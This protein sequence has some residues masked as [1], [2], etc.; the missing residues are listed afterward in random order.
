M[1]N[2]IKEF[3]EK[4]KDMNFDTFKKTLKHP[5]FAIDAWDAIVLYMKNKK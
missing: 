2:K 5:F 1:D 3:Y 4:Y